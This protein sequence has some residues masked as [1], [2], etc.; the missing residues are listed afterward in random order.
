MFVG[1]M[2]GAA[3][4]VGN[5]WIPINDGMQSGLTVQSLLI[6]R[7][8]LYAGTLGQ[9][10]WRAPLS[11]PTASVSPTRTARTAVKEM[12]V[13]PNP[14]V[15][16]AWLDF[17]LDRAQDVSLSLWNSVGAKVFQTSLL[18]LSAGSQHIAISSD[19]LTSLPSGVY[20]WRGVPGIMKSPLMRIKR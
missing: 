2:D 5:Q 9:G 6:D 15:D 10:V 16:R 13:S 4:R 17:D 18:S 20:F 19:V 11:A 14:V 7:D 12:R 1:S 3:V 8:T